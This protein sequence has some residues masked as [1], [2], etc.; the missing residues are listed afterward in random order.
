M[1]GIPMP[2]RVVPDAV[3]GK[4]LTFEQAVAH[5]GG[6][7]GMISDEGRRLIHENAK[8]YLWKYPDK[9]T[10]C[11]ACNRRMDG[12]YG[13]HGQR[14]ACPRCGANAEFRYEAR[15]HKWVFDSF[16]LYEWRK[17]AVDPEAVVL[18]AAYCCRN[19]TGPDPHLAPLDATPTALYVF[20]PGRAAT[21]YKR[22]STWGR[23][24]WE[25]YWEAVNSVHPEHTRWGDAPMDV[26]MDRM[27]FIHAL[28]GTRIGRL[29][30][31]L[32]PETNRFSDIELDAIAN[33]AR[34]PWLEYLYKAGQRHL[35]GQ[36]M[37]EAT[38][39]RDA[40]INQRAKT[41]RELLGLT[42]GQW[43]EIRRD[44]ICLTPDALRTLRAVKA[45]NI[46][47]IKVADAMRMNAGTDAAWHI[48]RDLLPQREGVGICQRLARL[49]GKLRRKILRR[50]LKDLRHSRDWRDYYY[51][52]AELNQVPTEGDAFTEADTALLLPKDMPEMHRRMTERQNAIARARRAEE[53]ARK[54]G[55][56]RR[57]LEDGLREGYTF[58]AAGLILRPYE[59]TAEVIDEGAALKICI[60][61]YAA[62]YAEGNTIIC[63]LR[64]AN[65]PDEPWRAVEFTPNGIL[66]QDRGMKNDMRGIPPGVRAQLRAFWNAWDKAHQ[67]S[68]RRKAG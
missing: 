13:H 54:D 58:Q 12:F 53:T 7:D 41:P 22:R 6:V 68:A 62:R 61:G 1:C 26:V 42:E 29:Y 16:Y 38:I 31:L 9:T 57:R 32:A 3:N 34:R 33:I 43:F 10:W 21:V 37:R 64:Q 39:P 23:N 24:G 11:T 52:L 59:S 30:D 25:P 44:D 63:C 19:S 40:G 49:P 50:I 51:Q 46:G 8:Q 28:E 5:V 67:T 48:N 20:R 4:R 55:A 47:E 65:E 35:A 66:V 17:S 56:L 18:T 45:L 27:Q 60:G 14:Y 15:G 2:P 36:L